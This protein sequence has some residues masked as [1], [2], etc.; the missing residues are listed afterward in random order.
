MAREEGGEHEEAGRPGLRAAIVRRD[1]SADAQ[2]ALREGV[3]HAGM[4]STTLPAH[5][6]TEPGAEPPVDGPDTESRPA[7]APQPPRG[8]APVAL[9]A[10]VAL[11]AGTVG[12]L[13]GAAVS[14]DDAVST[15]APSS[16]A[17]ANRP[18]TV[19]AG[20]LDLQQILAKVEP[21]VV[22][23]S[24]G[25]GFQSGAGTGIVLTPE[26][27]VLTNA[28]VVEGARTIRVTLPGAA[29]PREAE[30]LGADED[31]DLALLKIRDA[32]GLA[33]A[34]LGQS[35]DVQVGDDVVAVGNALA[36]RG[37]PTVTRGIVSAVNRSFGQLSGLLQHDAAINPGNSGGPLVNAG[38]QV[39]GVNTSVAGRG[40]GIGFAIPVDRAKDLL[41][42]LRSGG[43]SAPTGFLGVSTRDPEDGGRGAEIAEVTAGSP[44]DQAGLRS[45]DVITA[46]DGRAITGA[47]DLGGRIRGQKPGERVKVEYRRGTETRSTDVTLGRRPTS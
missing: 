9:I 19:T 38:G 35:S 33:I 39:I 43:S 12:G 10:V 1:I 3:H 41:T 14:D 46:V 30:L 26:G 6:P 45:G 16:S 22:G 8:R 44:A 29:Q 2:V 4:E 28:H 32:S 42:R 11:V 7:P 36:L 31:E 5:P 20:N 23:I 25:S 24:V 47:A 17:R 18:S 15:P 21:A 13:V 27:E 40:G 34:E 37:D